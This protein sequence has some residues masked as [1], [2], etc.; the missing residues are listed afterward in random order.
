MVPLSPFFAC[1]E[2]EPVPDPGKIMCLPL[3]PKS[4]DPPELSTVVLKVRAKL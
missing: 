1:K 4:L 3:V 2:F